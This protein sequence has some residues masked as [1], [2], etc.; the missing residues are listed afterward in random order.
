M[1][2]N[3][4]QKVP[5]IVQILNGPRY[6]FPMWLLVTGYKEQRELIQQSLVMQRQPIKTFST[7][8][9]QCFI[10]AKQHFYRA[11]N[12]RS[13]AQPVSSTY[14]VV[15]CLN[16]PKW[17]RS[18]PSLS[19]VNCDDICG[20]V[21]SLE[22]KQSAAMERA[23]EKD[24]QCHVLEDDQCYPSSCYYCVLPLCIVQHPP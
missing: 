7:K 22:R 4:L 3:L 10:H 2:N 18:T 12:C 13:S 19:S 8:Q 24:C 16:V 23:M 9:G 11:H 21:I 17:D 20:C 6:I 14:T 5:N 15:S 1:Y